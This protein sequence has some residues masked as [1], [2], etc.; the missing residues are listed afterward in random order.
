MVGEW[1]SD[2]DDYLLA[3][4]VRR[5]CVRGTAAVASDDRV[6]RGIRVVDV[7]VAL[8][9]IAGREGEA[10]QSALAAGAYAT[11]D[12]EEGRR[13][14]HAVFDDAYTTALLDDEEA[15]RPVGC[16]CEADGRREASDWRR[17]G[18]RRRVGRVRLLRGARDSEFESE[19]AETGDA[20]ERRED[21]TASHLLPSP[22]SSNDRSPH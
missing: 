12:V 10:E 13:L 5:V 1:L 21:N 2:G 14:K 3:R 15:S 9:R 8:L 22:F 16:V 4:G 17:D 7:E 19:A 11:G 18:E 20:Q 6:A